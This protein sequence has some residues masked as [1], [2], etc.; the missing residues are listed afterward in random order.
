MTLQQLFPPEK[1]P[2]IELI[3]DPFAHEV[4][5]VFADERGLPGSAPD[6]DYTGPIFREPPLMLD[7]AGRL[8]APD[9]Y[10]FDADAS[11]AANSDDDVGLVLPARADTAYSTPMGS[12]RSADATP[13]GS[14]RSPKALASSV[15]VEMMAGPRDDPLVSRTPSSG[16]KRQRPSPHRGSPM[17]APVASRPRISSLDDMDTDMPM[18]EDLDD[19]MTD[20]FWQHPVIDSAD[21]FFHCS[22]EGC[23]R[24]LRTSGGCSGIVKDGRRFCDHFCLMSSYRGQVS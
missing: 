7:L 2:G 22:A 12:P 8:H 19:F 6:Q 13:M 14:P 9:G 16:D 3:E 20:N 15:D 23:K 4:R 21:Q 5:D 18:D 10:A 24:D 1:Y 17:P 11:T